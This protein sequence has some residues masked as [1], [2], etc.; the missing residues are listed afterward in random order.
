MGLSRGTPVP[1]RS[2][3]PEAR[4]SRSVV[5]HFLALPPEPATDPTVRGRDCVMSR[6]WPARRKALLCRDM[7]SPASTHS[8]QDR[9]EFRS[10]IPSGVHCAG[11]FAFLT[12]DLVHERN[13]AALQS[14][15]HSHERLRES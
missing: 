12:R 5:D 9:P 13:N 6:A 8:D 7:Q 2:V 14:G 11:L 10:L 4:S 3:Q 15:S 1:F